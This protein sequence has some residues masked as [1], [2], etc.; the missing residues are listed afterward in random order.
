ML[1]RKIREQRSR[2]F[3]IIREQRLKKLIFEAQNN[4]PYAA[5]RSI[6]YRLVVAPLLTISLPAGLSW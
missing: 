1:R 3:L 5:I 4:E 2:M 6:E